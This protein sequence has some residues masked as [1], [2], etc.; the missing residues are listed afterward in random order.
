MEKK[1]PHAIYDWSPSLTQQSFK[2]ECDVNLIVKRFKDVNGVDLSTQNIGFPQGMVFGDF[3]NV[4][5]YRSAIEQVRR[6][7]EAFNSLDP[8][9]RARFDNDPSKFLDFCSDAKNI[10]EMRK[11]GL[12]RVSNEN[13]KGSENVEKTG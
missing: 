4:S 2:D 10:D 3:T 8:K 5:D 13:L 1:R 11:I 7:D 6:A 9:I 12:A